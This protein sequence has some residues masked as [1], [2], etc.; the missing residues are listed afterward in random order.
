[1]GDLES[2]RRY[3]EQRVALIRNRLLSAESIVAD[4]ACVYATGSF[5]RGEASSN[6]DLDLFIAGRN[7][8]GDDKKRSFTRLKEIRLKAKLIEVCEELEFPPFSGDGEYLAHY[9][10]HELTD[11]LGKPEDDSTNTFTARLLLVLESRCLLGDQV[12]ADAKQT[13][14]REYWR[15]YAGREASFTPA[16][17]CNDILRLW[18]TFCVN[19]EARTEREPD[20]QKAKG[21]IKNYK[22]KHSRLL[23]CYSA[24]LFLLVRFK[25]NQTVSPEDAFEMSELNPTLRLQ[26][27]LNEHPE[28]EVRDSIQRL[29][30]CYGRFLDATNHSD[31]QM[32]E[33]FMDREQARTKMK[34]AGEFGDAMFEVLSA[35]G[36]GSSLYRLLVV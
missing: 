21:K 16:F 31:E 7:E 34:Q 30:K 25:Q 17:L 28:P 15:D 10:M 18:R 20:R 19:Y 24:V 11:T 13:V 33:M 9:S 35:A 2:R 22:L 26:Q 6:S 3:S 23:T 5:G 27:I 14:I 4:N 8:S 36:A 12:Y 29:L 1:M 32:I